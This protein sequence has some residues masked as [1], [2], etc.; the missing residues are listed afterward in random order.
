MLFEDEKNI[1]GNNEYE[2]EIVSEEVSKKE[3]SPL[4]SE[5]KKEINPSNFERQNF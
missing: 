2:A 5:L 3:I 1:N 4:N